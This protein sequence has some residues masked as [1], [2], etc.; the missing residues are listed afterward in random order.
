MANSKISALTSATTP[1]AGTEVLPIVQSGATVKV[2]NNDLRP[3]QIQSNATSGVLQIAGPAAAATRVMT[4]PDA[5]FTVARTDASQTFTGTQTMGAA[6][7]TGGFRVGGYLATGA[8][9]YYIN[10]GN[11]GTV[12]YV[13]SFNNTTLNDLSMDCNT[14]AIRVSGYATAVSVDTSSNLSVGG[15]FVPGTAGKGVNFTTNTPAAGMTSQL[16]NW[17]EEG[18]WTPSLGG[19]ATYSVQAGKYTRVGRTVT[20]QAT[21]L[22][23]LIVT[24]STTT[25]SGLPFTSIGSIQGCVVGY[26][27]NSVT[28]V[29]S[30]M[31]RIPG[32]ST[33]IV[34]AGLTAAA[35][36]ITSPITFFQNGTYLE[37]NGTYQ[38][39]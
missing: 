29:V 11:S 18:T 10:V 17:Y 24:G 23:N 21:I 1:L 36:N 6:V 34:M 38:C 20:F 35:S 15:N 14:F 16:L 9:G 31:P 3:K 2:A 26:F 30:L 13:Q 37:I 32:S 4:T 39:V 8:F 33:T 12:N 7:S 19:I 5:N 25:I 27:T 28:S 22:V